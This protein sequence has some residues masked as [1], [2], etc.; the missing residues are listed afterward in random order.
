MYKR[1]EAVVLNTQRF[2]EA[3]LIVTHLTK[4]FG[5]LKTF[6][7]S[8]RK[9]KSRFGSSLEPLTIARIAFIGKEQRTLPRLIQSDIVRTNQSLREDM[10]LF[11]DLGECIR[12]ILQLFP[13]R[14]PEGALY[15]VFINTLEALAEGLPK[16]KL[17]LALKSRILSMAGHAPDV[18]RCVR[19]GGPS[20][21]FYPAEGGLLCPRCPD[22]EGP[23]IEIDER[24]KGLYNFILRAEPHH[25][26]R[27]KVP[28]QVWAEL[29]ELI[30]THIN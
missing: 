15:R 24:L 30:T 26:L 28:P 11:L 16:E 19:C 10:T 14:Y 27:I 22:R 4:D 7:K 8:P 12:L 9:I 1:T 20:K 2:S 21:R 6:A 18:T 5:L 13:E 25:I 17:L 23:F 29:E 3:D